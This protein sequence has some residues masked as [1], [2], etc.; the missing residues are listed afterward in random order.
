M[1]GGIGFQEIIVILIVGLLVFGAAR[2]PKIARSLGEGIREFKKTLSGIG[3][4]EEDENQIRSVHNQ[5]APHQKTTR[6][7]DQSV[8]GSSP[9][10][11]S[12]PEASDQQETKSD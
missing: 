4:P 5:T 8:K 3:D 9:S 12:D 6:A 1:L 11:Y 2:L 10:G 7:N